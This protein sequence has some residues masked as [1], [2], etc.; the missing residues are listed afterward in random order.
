[1]HSAQIKE[2]LAEIRSQEVEESTEQP[3]SN[4]DIK[5]TYRSPKGRKTLINTSHFQLGTL[6]DYILED[7]FSKGQAR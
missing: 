7:E 1:M 4:W 3:H 2:S 5:L 6:K